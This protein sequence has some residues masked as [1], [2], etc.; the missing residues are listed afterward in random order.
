VRSGHNEP[1]G[2]IVILR[3]GKMVDEFEESRTYGNDN[4]NET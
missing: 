3:S 1:R 4:D 2:E